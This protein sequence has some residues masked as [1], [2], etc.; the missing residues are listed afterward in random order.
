M[1]TVKEIHNYLRA[2]VFSLTSFVTEIFHSAVDFALDFASSRTFFIVR[3]SLKFLTF[4]LNNFSFLN[5]FLSDS[6][7]PRAPT[8]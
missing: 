4:S 2:A 6:I 8:A 7:Q 5:L 1:E 3:N